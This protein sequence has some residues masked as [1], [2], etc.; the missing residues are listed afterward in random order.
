LPPPDTA[1]A[2]DAFP[3]SGFY[4]DAFH[5]LSTERQIG[6]MGGAGHIP[7]SCAMAFASDAGLLSA[8]EREQFWRLIH[9]MDGSYLEWVGEKQKRDSTK[10]K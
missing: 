7:W 10:T 4:L 5:T 6:A 1:F 2:P 8:D 3:E 9:K